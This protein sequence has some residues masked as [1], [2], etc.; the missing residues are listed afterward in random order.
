ML[1]N[2]IKS[3]KSNL[4]KNNYK[5]VQEFKVILSKLSYYF[6]VIRLILS[7]FI[8]VIIYETFRNWW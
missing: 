1:Q 5:K 3:I 2:E 4:E 7:F 6:Y 8:L